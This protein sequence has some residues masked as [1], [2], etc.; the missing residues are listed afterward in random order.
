MPF[1]AYLTSGFQH[2]HENEAFD[3]LVQNLHRQF[4]SAPARHI[5]IGNVLIAGNE[6]DAV[7]FKPD[8]VAIIEIKDHGG[9]VQFSENNPWR[10]DGREVKGGTKIN[11]FVQ[12]RA[13]RYSLR[14]WLEELEH[15]L[16]LHPRSRED[17]RDIA[18]LVLFTRDIQFDDRVLIGPLR[19]W[20]QIT[21]MARAADRLN[22]VRARALRFKDDEFSS[23]L[24]RLQLGPEHEYTKS[25][26][27]SRVATKAAPISTGRI[28]LSYVKELNFRDHE[29]RMRNFGG[30]RFLG[31]QQMREWF[32]QVRQGLNPFAEAAKRPDGRLVGAV[33]YPVNAACELILIE[34]GTLAIPAFIG[35]PSEVEGWLDAHK[36]LTVSLDHATGRVCIT[37]VSATHGG[38]EMQAPALTTDNQSFLTRVVGLDYDELIPQALARQHL[39]ALDE[40]STKEE[41]KQ[42][43]ELVFDEGLRSFLFDVINLVRAGDHVGAQ[44]R[45][46]LR[47]G[48]ALPAE[49][50]G[51]FAERAA[52]SDVNSDQVMVIN[53]LS[54]EQLDR[55]LD[56]VNF[57][58]W[59]LFLHPDQKVLADGKFDRP[60]VLKGVSGSG[61]TC[62]LVHRARTLAQRYPG[63]RIGILT[64][65]RTLAGLLQNLVT[66]LCSDDERKN[67]EVLAFYDVFRDCLKHLGPAKYFAQLAE[68]VTEQAH[69][70]TVLQQ[71]QE[72]W[73]SRMVWAG[74]PIGNQNVEEEWEQFY[75]SQHPDIQSWMGE[76]EK[77]LVEN[78]IDASRYIEE[79]FTLI[80][81]AFTVPTRDNYLSFARTGRSVPFREE[82]RKDALRLLLFWEEWLLAGGYIDALGLTQAL[83][84]L[85]SEMQRLPESLRFRCLLVDEFQDFS[86][87]DL[88]LL[89]RVVPID[90]PDAL[91][92]A[93]DTVQRIL[94]KRLTLSDAGFDT[95][96][97]THHRIKKNYR[98]SRQILRAASKLANHYGS[99]A[100]SQGEEIE[101]LDP[102]LAQRETNPPI[103][104]KTDDQ[105]VKAWE[106]ALECTADQKAEPWTVCIVTAAP[107]KVTVDQ[108]LNLRPASL[109]AE[110]LSGDCILHPDKIVV[111]TISDLKGFE[112][113]LVL[114]LGCDAGS[115]PPQGTPSDEVWRD[116]LRLYVAMTRG[117][118]QVFLLHEKEPS[119]FIEIMGDTVVTREEPVFRRYA[120]AATPAK[121]PLTMQRTPAPAH[122][123]ASGLDLDKNCETWFSDDE[124]DALKRYFARHVYRDGLTF[125]EWCIPRGLSTLSCSRFRSLPKCRRAL[126]ER[127]IS[128]LAAKGVSIGR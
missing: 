121:T 48:E 81:S 15:Q 100:G 75:M 58:E 127:V 7:L 103:I 31:A 44:E 71:A 50:A 82:L 73:P 83:M 67:I 126:I 2:R 9:T 45:I 6:M 76:L 98:N 16:E 88:Q 120:V 57:H 113:R 107:Q 101:V 63:Q 38:S 97:A 4:D 99:M 118:D 19:Y 69:M 124:L 41:I 22:S 68:Q 112:F 39:L 51:V 115:F 89:R 61:K 79:E 116:A 34:L 102:E 93:G 36:G 43:L 80:R 14:S 119:L 92:L 35:M 33:I 42:S 55:L 86:T 3:V 117:R 111:G 84:P 108:I 74:S 52:A 95:G 53:D 60:V 12:V 85:H 8:G 18:A 104:L 78:G 20:F 21:D 114:I 90:Q 109:A 125:H 70:H 87:L 66:Q 24:R 13:Y 1:T 65:S 10:A 91:F 56:P 29:L 94:V 23:I 62:I 123:A 28:Q 128:K 110:P 47:S 49:D 54:K 77:Y 32:E 26:V 106:I 37:R 40:I 5:L 59:M 11:P 46:R 27:P 105:V 64:L 25:L 30:Q 72:K 122:A 96:A 17:W